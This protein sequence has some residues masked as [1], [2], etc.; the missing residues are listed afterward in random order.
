MGDDSIP[1][2]VTKSN[3]LRKMAKHATCT[4]LENQ[5]PVKSSLFK[6]FVH[7]KK[8]SRCVSFKFF[9]VRLN[10]LWVYVLP[11]YDFV[12]TGTW[13]DARISCLNQFFSNLGTPRTRQK[14]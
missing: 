14:A 8:F 6:I 2:L 13:Q 10:S 9:A 11:E 12:N 3:A 7:I 1:A 4:I 5:H